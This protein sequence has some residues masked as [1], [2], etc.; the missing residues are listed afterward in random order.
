MPRLAI[1]AIFTIKP[2][3]ADDFEPVMKQAIRD[4]L[5]EPGTEYYVGSSYHLSPT[6]LNHH[7]LMPK[8]SHTR[9]R[10]E[11]HI[12]RIRDLQISRGVSHAPL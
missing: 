11:E 10:N 7:I 4:S 12:P 9:Q 2:E 3:L 8:H 1:H 6:H 5:A